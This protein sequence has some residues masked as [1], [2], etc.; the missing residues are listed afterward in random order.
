MSPS[1]QQ[2]AAGV[3]PV[4]R[5]QVTS[6]LILTVGPSDRAGATRG[7]DNR[8]CVTGRPTGKPENWESLIQ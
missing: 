3:F 5:R 6:L 8:E 4:R 1:H 2:H 7:T